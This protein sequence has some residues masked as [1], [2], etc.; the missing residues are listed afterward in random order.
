MYL[1]SKVSDTDKS[2]SKRENTLFTVSRSNSRR[3]HWRSTTP[4]FVLPNK[5]RIVNS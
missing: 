3:R 5:Q 1:Y 4:Q 2:M